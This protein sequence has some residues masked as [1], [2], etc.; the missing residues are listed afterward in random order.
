YSITS[1]SLFESASYEEFKDKK[2]DIIFV[3]GLNNDTYDGK[4]YYDEKL[5]IN[6]GFVSLHD[7]N[8]YFGYVKKMLLTLYNLR[9]MHKGNLPIHGAMFKLT[10]KDGK[11]K[12]V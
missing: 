6:L 8:D 10:F 2:P 4:Y 12:N 7:K 11:E 9:H 5:D 3:Y 1:G